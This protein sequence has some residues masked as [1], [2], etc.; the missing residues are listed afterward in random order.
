MGISDTKPIS[1]S[2]HPS[3]RLD[4]SKSLTRNPCPCRC[5]PKQRCLR[6][7]LPGPVCSG[8][9]RAPTSREAHLTRSRAHVGAGMATGNK[10]KRGPDG[11]FCA[12]M[13]VTGSALPVCPPWVAQS[14]GRPKAPAGPTQPSRRRVRMARGPYSLEVNKVRERTGVSCRAG[15]K[16]RPMMK[17]IIR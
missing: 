1:A 10:T 7:G 16:D 17:F 14:V 4:T 8:Q 3:S 6:S 11:Q 5:L 9:G 15:P 2:N 12:C 13:T